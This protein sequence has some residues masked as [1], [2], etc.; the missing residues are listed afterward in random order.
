MNQKLVLHSTKGHRLD[1]LC[2]HSK[3]SFCVYDSGYRDDGD[4]ALNIKSVIVFGK[5][6][7]IDDM[8]T[9]VDVSTKLSHKFTQ[10]EAYIQ[11]E[12]ENYAKETLLLRLTPE[13]MTG[14]KVK[15]A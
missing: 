13:H 1:A 8:E 7:V 12:I 2:N 9:I 4:W 14:K 15:E 10:D 6:D 3:V 11:A 5:M